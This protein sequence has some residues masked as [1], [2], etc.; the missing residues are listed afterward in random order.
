MS[1]GE[2]EADPYFQGA[3]DDEQI[4]DVAQI[5]AKIEYVG[6]HG[7]PSNR[8]AVNNLDKGVWEFKHGWH[9]LAY[10][11]TPGDGSFEPKERVDDR[12]VCDPDCEDDYWWYPIMD[13]VL[14]LTNG[15]SKEGQMAP[16]EAVDV[17]LA[18][19]EEDVKHDGC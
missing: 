9:R 12:R 10:F 2:W 8:T 15:W 17:A 6:V 14:R 18:I 13:S 19:R 1:A 11:D 3:P 7:E 16:P 5:F 4:H